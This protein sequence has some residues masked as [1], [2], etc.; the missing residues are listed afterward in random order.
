MTQARLIDTL[1]ELFPAAQFIVTTHSP[2]ILHTLSPK[3]IIPLGMDEDRN[4]HIKKLNLGEYGLKGWTF[5]GNFKR[6]YGD[7]VYEFKKI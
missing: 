6:C 3:E 7:A 2:S 5:G 4:V 1:K